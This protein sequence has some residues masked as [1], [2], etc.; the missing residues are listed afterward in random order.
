MPFEPE[1]IVRIIAVE[2]GSMVASYLGSEGRVLSK[3]PDLPLYEIELDAGRAT[4]ARGGQLG[5]RFIVK[6]AH[7]APDVTEQMIE[8]GEAVVDQHRRANP[9][10]DIF[11][12]AEIKAIYRAMRAARFDRS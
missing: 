6:E 5:P 9:S 8:A 12:D 11:G 3:H 2:P 10:M 1:D 7:L 4:P